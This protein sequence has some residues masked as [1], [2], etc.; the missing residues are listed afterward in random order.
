[1][2]Q[3]TAILLP[4]IQ[5]LASG[6][7]A[8]VAGYLFFNWLRA[9]V[10]VDQASA[11]S[12]LFHAPL[13]ARILALL[14]TGLISVLFSALG[15]FLLGGDVFRAVDEAAAAMLSMVIATVTHGLTNLPS[16]VTDPSRL[17]W[18]GEKAPDQEWPGVEGD[19]DA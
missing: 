3:T 7:G 11:L 13:Y 4:F 15:A 14:L 17:P 6:P 16:T 18:I 19:P 8:G 2:T 9:R 1:M 10:P 5:Y 12:C